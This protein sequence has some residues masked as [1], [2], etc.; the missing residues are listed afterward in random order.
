MSHDRWRD[1]LHHARHDTG[2]LVALLGRGTPT[3][4]LQHAGS[5]LL[6]AGPSADLNE[7]CA[8]LASRLRDRGWLGDVELATALMDRAAGH[9]S[10]LTAL[11][12]DLD[13]LAD[14]IDAQTSSESYIDLS[15]AAVWPGEIIELGQGPDDLD[16]GDA[17][18]W[19]FVRGEGSQLAYADMEHFIATVEPDS[20]S[21]KLREAI[22]GKHPFKAF[23]TVLQR[24]DEQF[25]SWH[26]HRD[27]A[28]IGRARHWLAEHGF[29]AT[30]T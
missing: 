18:R 27:D 3:N 14:L 21:V 30:R 24:N 16:P 29:E 4:G 13:E 28:R 26:R 22:T 20:L 1:E 19:L 17:S 25:T 15:S 8:D 7:V 6:A 23:L 10:S 9:P 2:R 11:A 12:V 5:A